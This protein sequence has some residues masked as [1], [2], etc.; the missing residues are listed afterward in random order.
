VIAEED[1]MMT[2]EQMKAEIRIAVRVAELRRL[3]ER[4]AR[5]YEADSHRRR[6][7]AEQSHS[8]DLRRPHPDPAVPN[9]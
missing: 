9:P 2:R 5:D 6:Q 4:T 8:P 7:G 1:R 3:A